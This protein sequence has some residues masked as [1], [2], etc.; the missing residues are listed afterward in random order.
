MGIRRDI[1]FP[2][3][4]FAELALG[5]VTMV[6]PAALGA[7]EV[8]IVAS[9]LFGATLI[10]LA[11]SGIGTLEHREDRPAMAP[12]LHHVAD[13]FVVVGLVASAVLLGFGGDAVAATLLALVALGT[14]TLEL[15]TRYRATA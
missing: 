3:H 9:V 8:G 12:H 1:S 4:T 6:V 11:L 7:S 2:T 13:Q 10:G 15:A 14:R 5:L